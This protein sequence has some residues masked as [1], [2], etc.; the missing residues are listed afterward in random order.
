M[1]FDKN[2]DPVGTESASM[3]IERPYRRHKKRH[4]PKI[5][6]AQPEANPVDTVVN[7]PPPPPVAHEPVL[8]DPPQASSPP[9]PVFV[10][11]PHAPREPATLPPAE[12][13]EPIP[14][15]PAQASPPRQPVFTLPARVSPPR[16]PAVDGSTQ[17]QPPREAALALPPRFQHKADKI[18]PIFSR[19]AQVEPR[20]GPRPSSSSRLPSNPSTPPPSQPRSP[21]LTPSAQASSTPN[22][23]L[24]LSPLSRL[25]HAKCF[26]PPHSAKRTPEALSPESSTPGSRRRGAASSPFSRSGSQ[27]PAALSTSLRAMRLG[28]VDSQASP[29]FDRIIGIIRKGASGGRPLT[30]AELALHTVPSSVPIENDLLGDMDDEENEDEEDE[31]EQKLIEGDEDEEDGDEETN[32]QQT[33]DDDEEYESD[34]KEASPYRSPRRI[35]PHHPARPGKA[36]TARIPI[37]S[38]ETCFRIDAQVAKRTAGKIVVRPSQGATATVNVLKRARDDT[39]DEEEEH[40]RVRRVRRD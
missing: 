20:R 9:A 11:S 33:S 32:E 15:S 14:T 6:R 13:H 10:P 31:I 5:R 12:Q 35:T 8:A 27:K 19:P 34:A 28:E 21:A 29:D 22:H 7:A 30:E 38:P 24:A 4:Y 3:F 18:L 23:A 17:E 25:S 16:N 1:G 39:D 26:T 37:F 36:P 40:G 2:G